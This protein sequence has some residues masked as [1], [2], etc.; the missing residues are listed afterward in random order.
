MEIIFQILQVWL[1]ASLGFT[2]V[3]AYLKVN[4]L[5]KRKH[6]RKV[7]EAQSIMGSCVALLAGMPFFFRYVTRSDFESAVGSFVWLSVSVFIIFVGSGIWLQREDKK[8]SFFRLIKDALKLEGTEVGNLAK[9]LIRH[10][11]GA[12]NMVEILVQIA[13]IDNEFHKKEREFIELFISKW[14]INISLNDFLLYHN[15]NENV[16]YTTLLKAVEDYLEILPPEKQVAQLI[17]TINELIHVDDTITIEEKMT[18]SEVTSMLRDYINQD[19]DIKKFEVF[20]VPR[21]Q[22]QEER[23]LSILFDY[24][25]KELPGGYVFSVAE[26]FSEDYA[27][28][29]CEEYRKLGLFAI[30]LRIPEVIE[31]AS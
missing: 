31:E 1:W 30:S 2:F 22:E 5:W 11:V 29:V 24:K 7:A 17:D 20:I 21:N 4:K 6:E 8:I 14:N 16:N 15:K 3:E 25:R 23:A 9:A 27:E 28:M 18:V 26:Y 12:K 13:H 19:R 10:P